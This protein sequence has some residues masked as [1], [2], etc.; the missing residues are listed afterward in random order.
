MVQQQVVP[1]HVGGK[2]VVHVPQHRVDV[3]GAVLPVVVLHH[4]VAA[5][6]PVVVRLC[7]V[8]GAAPGQVDL[9]QARPRAARS[10]ALRPGRR[11][12]GVTYSLASAI[13]ISRCV[14]DMA[15]A[16]SP[17]SLGSDALEELKVMMSAGASS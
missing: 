4:E 15:V 5:V 2:V 14:P 9:L 6:Q 1:Q 8:N 12:P 10:A 11:G 17:S 3:V 7:A 13:S 16:G